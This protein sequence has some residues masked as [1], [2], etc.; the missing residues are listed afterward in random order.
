MTSRS[1]F[2]SIALSAT[3]L[4]SGLACSS[5]DTTGTTGTGGSSAAST[6]GSGDVGGGGSASSSSSGS[7]SSTSSGTGGSSAAPSFVLVHGAWMGAWCWDEVGA[8]LKAKGA[9][10][11]TVELPA[12][13][14]D[15]T[16]LAGATLDAYVAKV[17]DAVTAA[18]GPVYLVGHSLAGVVIT[19]VAEKLPAK[20]TGLVYLAAFLPKEGETLQGLAGMDAASHLGPNL[21][22]DA[23]AGVAKIP[24]D[25]LQDIFCADCTAKQMGEIS[26]HYRDEPLAP[27]VAPSHVTPAAWGKVTKYYVFA[28]QDHAISYAMQQ[29]MTTGV[30]FAKTATLDR[31]HS[32]FLSSSSEV[33]DT[34]LT[35]VP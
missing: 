17:G 35:F 1:I 4:V 18:T 26:A 15:M 34:L 30:T 22:I 2:L 12:H 20:I 21:Q 11:T 9:T 3:S 28:K 24:M 6:T 33:I 8:G 14:A 7:G 23:A 13:G 27:F 19:N 32:P 16:P 31:S 25:K 10:V 29:T 5:S